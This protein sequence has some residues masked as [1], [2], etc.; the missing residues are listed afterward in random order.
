M[1]DFNLWPRSRRKHNESGPIDPQVSTAIS[2]KL[3]NLSMCLY[4][5]AFSLSAMAAV[6]PISLA[7]A[8]LLELQNVSMHI[9]SHTRNFRQ[10]IEWE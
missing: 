3:Y 2:W 7:D 1:A 9:A 8:H 6:P 5:L 10:I 4:F